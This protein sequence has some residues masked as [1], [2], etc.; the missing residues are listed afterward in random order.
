[1]VLEKYLFLQQ[2]NSIKIH[3]IHTDQESMV[4]YYIK[5]IT[6]QG[7]CDIKVL[8]TPA[9]ISC[10]ER[11]IFAHLLMVIDEDQGLRLQHP[12]DTCQV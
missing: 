10:K 12:L 11:N 4:H 2:Y 3:S 9:M 6:A 7:C 8:R 1:M 5:I